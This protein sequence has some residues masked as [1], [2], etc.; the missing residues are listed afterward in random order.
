MQ[1]AVTTLRTSIRMRVVAGIAAACAG[2]LLLA[3]CTSPSTGHETPKVTS[4]HR[5]GD[6]AKTAIKKI[7]ASSD[8]AKAIASAKGTI[9]AGGQD[10]PSAVVAEIL[11]VEALPDSTELVWRLKSANGDTVATN[12]FQLSKPPFLSTRYVGL[13]DAAA[14]KTYFPY[15]YAPAKADGADNACLCSG[16]PDEVGG[17]GTVLYSVMPPLPSSLATVDVTIPGFDPITDVKVSRD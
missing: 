7:M 14:K 12:S 8:T 6:S 13:I 10:A 1:S 4:S 5:D 9:A 16:I 11:Q 15:T 2:A 17:K 3:G